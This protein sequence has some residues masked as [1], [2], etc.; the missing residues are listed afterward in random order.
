MQTKAS[1]NVVPL[2]DILL[3]LLIIFMVITPVT[4]ASIDVSLPEGDGEPKDPPIVLTI[5]KEG[6]VNVNTRTFESLDILAG[7]LK[8]LYKPRSNKTIYVQGHKRVPYRYVVSVID[9]IKGADIS[10]ICMMTKPYQYR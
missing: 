9:V 3:V 6:L 10:T 7:W 4:Q 1:P 8:E 5:E 2:C